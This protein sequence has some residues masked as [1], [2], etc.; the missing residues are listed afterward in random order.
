MRAVLGGLRDNTGPFVAAKFVPESRGGHPVGQIE[1]TR[2]RDGDTLYF[3]VLPDYAVDDK[4][5]KEVDVPFPRHRHV[6]DVR[7]R[8]YLGEGGVIPDVLEPGQPKMYAAFRYKV[9]GVLAECPVDVQRGHQA[10]VKIRVRGSGEMVGPH[11]VR[12]EVALPDGTRP[13]YLARTVYLPE[14]RGSYSL[15]PALNTPKGDWRIMMTEC[16]SGV[17][18][19]RII[20]IR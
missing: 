17:Q 11:A 2:F 19:S 15:T 9:T 5:P 14:G 16:A 10:D 13:E 3:G 20:R 12:I 8:R 6:Y 4:R 18:G 7:A 1:V